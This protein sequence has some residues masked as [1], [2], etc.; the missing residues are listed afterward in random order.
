MASLCH[1]LDCVNL[2]EVLFTERY[3]SCDVIVNMIQQYNDRF[4]SQGSPNM[5]RL[6]DVSKLLAANNSHSVSSLSS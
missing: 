2:P 3:N 4:T 1:P 5:E 6:A